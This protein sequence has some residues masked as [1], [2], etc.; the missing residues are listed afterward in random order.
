MIGAFIVTQLGEFLLDRVFGN[1]YPRF[2]KISVDDIHIGEFN[3]LSAVISRGGVCTVTNVYLGVQI[4]RVI[5]GKAS[6]EY[7]SIISVS[8]YHHSDDYSDALDS[9][10]DSFIDT[11]CS[12]QYRTIKSAYKKSGVE[13]ISLSKIERIEYKS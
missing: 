3:A 9:I 10:K 7:S 5:G 4:T 12:E 13:L 1:I 11:E 6:I 2:E 8:R